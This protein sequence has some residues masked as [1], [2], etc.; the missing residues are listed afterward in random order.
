MFADVRNDMRIAREEI[1]G[2]VLSVLPFDDVDEAVRI[3]ND[4]PYGLGGA[5]YATDVAKA[6]EVAK[7]IR[8]GTLNINSAFNLQQPPVRR[9][10]GERHRPRGRPLG[11]RTSTRRSRRSRGSEARAAVTARDASSRSAA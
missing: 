2:P 1:F 11:D 7:R 6:L 10:Q 3:A 8:T 5:I 9:L 4:S